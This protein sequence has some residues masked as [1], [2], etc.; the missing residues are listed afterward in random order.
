MAWLFA[1]TIE[2]TDELAIGWLND[3]LDSL[4]LPEKISAKFAT[5]PSNDE[6]IAFA[7]WNPDYELLPVPGVADG[8][9][10]CQLIP[11]SSLDEVLVSVSEILKAIENQSR[12]SAFHTRLVVTPDRIAIFSPPL[13]DAFNEEPLEKL[14]SE[15]EQELSVI[16][17]LY[18]LITEN[19]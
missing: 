9:W 13:D 11:W 1:F 10:N 12:S 3:V 19:T 15:L 4:S 2:S 16:D 6:F 17:S 18:R 8:E 5:T 7:F 14:I